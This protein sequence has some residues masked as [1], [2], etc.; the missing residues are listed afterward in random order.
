[1]VFSKKRKRTKKKRTRRKRAGGDKEEGDRC[2]RAL[3]DRG[4]ECKS[5]LVCAPKWIEIPANLD[6]YLKG[7]GWTDQE[8]ADYMEQQKDIDRSYDPDAALMGDEF[9]GDIE[10]YEKFLKKIHNLGNIYTDEEGEERFDAGPSKQTYCIPKRLGK[11]K[12]CGDSD[13]LKRIGMGNDKRKCEA[14]YKCIYNELGNNQRQC[15]VEKKEEERQWD[16]DKM[17][18][19]RQQELQRAVAS[20]EE[21]GPGLSEALG[22][23][24]EKQLRRETGYLDDQQ[25]AQERRA[26]NWQRYGDRGKRGHGG[27]RR[28]KKRKKRKRRRK[29]RTRRRR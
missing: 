11:D 26:H 29:K 8:I 12:Y 3:T 10:K 18:E 1:M 28:T 7:Q 22:Q 13:Y 21:S 5:G 25:R 9:E 19:E 23:I 27:K 6:S 4:S 20:K 17:E 2:K 16:P 24:A 14:P 15:K